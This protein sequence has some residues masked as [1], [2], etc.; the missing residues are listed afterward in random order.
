MPLYVADYL[1]D[2]GHLTTTEHGAYLLLL[3]TMWRA[4]G[5]LP[6]DDLRLAR[7]A[8][9]TRLQWDRM[10]PTLI[11]FFTVLDASIS[12]K[13]MTAELTKYTYAVERQRVRSSNGGKAKSLKSKKGALPVAMPTVCQPEPEPEDRRRLLHSHSS[14]CRDES[15]LPLEGQSLLSLQSEEDTSDDRKA[16]ADEVRRSVGIITRSMAVPK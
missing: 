14:I 9:C 10:R 16:L 13:R 15:I 3:M 2:T 8:R 7:F 12:H 1:G 4:G 6:N 5:S 11:E